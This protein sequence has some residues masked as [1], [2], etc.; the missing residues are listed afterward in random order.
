MTLGCLNE[1]INVLKIGDTV[2][3]DDVEYVIEKQHN[4]KVFFIGNKDS[5]VEMVHESM[6]T[7]KES[8]MSHGKDVWYWIIILWI[9]VFAILN[10]SAL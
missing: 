3:Y 10:L 8:V 7:R 2:L 6:L 4:A 5:F 9:V 1:S